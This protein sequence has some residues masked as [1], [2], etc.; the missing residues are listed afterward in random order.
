MPSAAEVFRP[1]A[2]S[3]ESFICCTLK[4]SSTKWLAQ[5]FGTHNF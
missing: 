3:D 4:F 5:P 2:A 1:N